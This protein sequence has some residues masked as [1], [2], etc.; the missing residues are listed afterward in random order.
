MSFYADG[1]VVCL[2]KLNNKKSSLWGGFKRKD[3]DVITTTY[4]LLYLYK[5]KGSNNLA[6]Y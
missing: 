6:V 4:I 2:E 3:K 5:P 1:K